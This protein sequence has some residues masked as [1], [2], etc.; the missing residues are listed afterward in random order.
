MPHKDIEARRKYHRDYKER[1]GKDVLKRK[2]RAW[3]LPKVYG[4]SLE[5]YEKL[6]LNQNFSCALCLRSQASFKRGYSLAV[7]HNHKTGEIRGLLC[8]ACNKLLGRV[9]DVEYFTRVRNYLDKDDKNLY[10]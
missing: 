10:N 1:V 4:I 3:R 5:D 9:E 6:L 2:H 7:D 8:Y